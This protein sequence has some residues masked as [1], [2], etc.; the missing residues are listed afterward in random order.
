MAFNTTKLL[1]RS[2]YQNSL[3]CFSVHSLPDELV[4]LQNMCRT[5][6]QNELKPIAARLDKE[7]IFPKE[8]INK[9]A[10]L[11]LM[12]IC[13]PKKWGGSEYSTLGLAV[14]VEEIAKGCSGTGAT[15]SIH[16]CLYVDLLSRCGTD[17]QKEQFLK[18][19]TTGEVGCFALSEAGLSRCGTDKQKEQFLKPFTTGEVGCFALSEADAGSDVSG[20]TTTARLEGDH[21]ILN[22]T[23]SWVTSGS[24]G[25][26][27]VIFA[28]VDKHLKHKGISAFLVPLPSPG[29][30]WGKLE[31]KLGIRASPTCSFILENVHVPRENVLGEIG[32]GFKIA[33][34]QLDK[35]RI[36]IAAQAVGIGQAALDVAVQYAAHR[37]TFGKP[38]SEQQAVKL[39]LADMALRIESARLLVWRAAVMHDQS[40]KSTKESSMAKWAASEAA[41]F[42]THAAIQVLGGM[43]YVS[44]MPAERYYRDARITEIY[45]GITDIQKLVIGDIII[46]EYG[47]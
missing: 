5:F 36:G 20:I 42:V 45:G 26:A 10:Q 24:I 34:I 4:S 15:V 30:S 13:V 28:T 22:G 31:D 47:Y 35:A 7:S 19:F 44:D 3:R 40:Q 38:I 2:S 37:K 32:E 14:A 33:M 25:K 46:K 11:G 23:K 8:Q 27:A 41:T 17:K 1:I 18:P 9:L 6:A 43:G 21:Y 29:L 39:R 16:N 12:S